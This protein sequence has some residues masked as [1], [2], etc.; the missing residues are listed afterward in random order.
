MQRMVADLIASPARFQQ[1]V[2]GESD[3][4]TADFGAIARDGCA[5]R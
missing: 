5:R 3:R 1:Q 4:G 2:A